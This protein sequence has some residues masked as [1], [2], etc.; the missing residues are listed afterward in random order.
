MIDRIDKKKFENLKS[1]KVE[2]KGNRP[3]KKKVRHP[4]NQNDREWRV[5]MFGPDHGIS[6]DWKQ[7]IEEKNAYNEKVARER[8]RRPP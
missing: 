1:E 5:R 8:A 2:E 6:E 4:P 7:M 3:R